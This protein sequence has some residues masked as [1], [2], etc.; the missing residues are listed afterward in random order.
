MAP[1]VG[2]HLYPFAGDIGV[3]GA[4]RHQGFIPWDD[5][6][7]IAMTRRDYQKLKKIAKKEWA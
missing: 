2:E 5:D 6:V 3:I 1:D 4:A 7:D